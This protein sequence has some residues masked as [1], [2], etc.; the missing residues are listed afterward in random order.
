MNR[1][2]QV[3]LGAIAVLA[4]IAGPAVVLSYELTQA[5]ATAPA[6]APDAAAAPAQ[7]APAAD[8]TSTQTKTASASDPAKDKDKP[9]EEVAYRTFPVVGSRVAIWAV[10]QL[11][12]LFAAFVLAVPLFAFIIEVIGY[13]T[14]DVR[15]DRLAYEFTKL[16]SVPF[17]LT[18][19]FEAFMTFM[20]LL[21]DHRF[22]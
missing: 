20:L 6:P 18:E 2:L 17:S 9:Y 7:G 22:T 10:A 4:I 15:Y 3:L 8:T 13:K 19:T 1:K 12:L 16:L 11:H 14:G 5:P 21:L